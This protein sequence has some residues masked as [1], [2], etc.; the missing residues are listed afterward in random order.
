[1]CDIKTILELKYVIKNKHVGILWT[2]I[3]IQ[4]SVKLQIKGIKKT[5]KTVSDSLV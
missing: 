1:M 2:K 3:E 5:L 4:K